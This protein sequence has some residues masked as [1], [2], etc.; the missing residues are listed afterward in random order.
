M[1]YDEIYRTYVSILYHISTLL[2]DVLDFFFYI[3]E[4]SFYFYFFE[5]STVDCI[6]TMYIRTSMSVESCDFLYIMTFI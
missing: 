2:F 6:L 3:S 5:F 1:I 4:Q